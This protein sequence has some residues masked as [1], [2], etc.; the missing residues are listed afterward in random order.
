MKCQA[1]LQ[2]SIKKHRNQENQKGIVSLQ[3]Y[4]CQVSILGYQARVW[5]CYTGS[6][7][8]NIIP[9]DTLG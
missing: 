2:K 9:L 1:C 3:L 8:V 6:Q 5:V 7:S 4:I